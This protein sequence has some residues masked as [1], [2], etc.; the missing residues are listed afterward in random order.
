MK[1]R[2]WKQAEVVSVVSW[3]DFCVEN[4]LD[5]CA[6]I[7]EHLKESPQHLEDETIPLTS[8]QIKSKLTD[9]GRPKSIS[10]HRPRHT[11]FPQ[12]LIKGSKCMVNLPATLMPR[13]SAKLDSLRSGAAD[14]SCQTIPHKTPASGS[15]AADQLGLSSLL[16]SPSAPRSIKRKHHIYSGRSQKR[17][18]CITDRDVVHN[19]VPQ[20]E[21][22]E[23]TPACCSFAYLSSRQL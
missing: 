1:S 9:L 18:L 15:C 6:T 17:R 7:L 14:S 5:F 16:E 19:N 23:V 10:G 3:L 21:A 13:I 2:M 12:I 8:K 22:P 11:P 20:H 4:Q